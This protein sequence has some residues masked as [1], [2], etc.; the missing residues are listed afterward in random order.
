MRLHRAII[1][2]IFLSI[3]AGAVAQ[4]TEHPS[5]EISLLSE[6][7]QPADWDI[8]SL[9]R[10][11]SHGY[12]WHVNPRGLHAW[13]GRKLI[14]YSLAPDTD[15]L[16]LDRE[17][18][19][20][21]AIAPS[22][23]NRYWLHHQDPRT[24]LHTLYLW[25][26]DRRTIVSVITLEE[27]VH[28]LILSYDDATERSYLLRQSVARGEI[29]VLKL[30]SDL[31]ELYRISQSI[32]Q[33]LY[34]VK[35]L[36][37]T[38]WVLKGEYL[39][40]YDTAGHQIVNI[41]SGSYLK[42]E[43]TDAL[44]LRL[45]RTD[46]RASVTVDAS[47]GRLIPVDISTPV[48]SGTT[49]SSFSFDDEIWLNDFDERIWLYHPGTGLTEDYTQVMRLLKE[50][51]DIKQRTGDLQLV[52]SY[53]DGSYLLVYQGHLYRADP[54][55]A[56]IDKWRVPVSTVN[57]YPSIRQI[58]D[59]SA[60]NIYVSYY[61][62]VSVKRHDEDHF[63][64][65]DLNPRR[66]F[67]ESYS[68]VHTAT[69]LIWDG[70]RYR[71][72]DAQLSKLPGLAKKNT[73]VILPEQ[74][75]LWTYSRKAI[76]YKTIMPQLEDTVIRRDIFE[77]PVIGNALL[78]NANQE[79][80]AFI[81]A[82]DI[83]G[84]N[85]LR[86][87]GQIVKQLRGVKL[88]LSDD[89]S[90]VSSLYQ[91]DDRLYYGTRL[92]IG[93]LEA[94]SDQGKI[95]PE[96]TRL[97][98][99]QELHDAIYFIHPWKEAHLLLGTGSGLLLFDLRTSVIQRLPDSHPLGNIE[100][101]RNAH[102]LAS[103]GYTYVGSV[104]G[105]F[106]IDPGELPFTPQMRWSPDLSVYE[107][108]TYDRQTDAYRSVSSDLMSQDGPIR[109]RTTDELMTIRL[110]APSMRGD[111]WYAYSMEGGDGSWS[112]YDTRSDIELLSLPTGHFTVYLRAS[113]NPQ[114]LHYTEYQ[115][116]YFRPVIWYE[117][118][119]LRTLGALLL[120]GAVIAVVV[121]RFRAKVNKEKALNQWRI[122]VSSD[123]HDD[124]GSILSG[125]AMQSEIMSMSAK[126][127]D[128]KSLAEINEMS[129]DAMERMRDTVW[130]IDSRKDKYENLID[131][132]RAFAMKRLP[133]ERWHVD[134]HVVGIE[135]SEK[136]K[137][138]MRQQLYLIH[139]EAITN[140]QKH[141][142]GNQDQTSRSANY[143]MKSTMMALSIKRSV[144]M[145]WE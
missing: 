14:T 39:A 130:L 113:A 128:K 24:Y 45:T 1:V 62:D 28:S 18:Q 134:F 80:S 91:Y 66:S 6:A 43:N 81:L 138:V 103:D 87:D 55:T 145:V 33:T 72:S 89:D 116:E 97:I 59:D 60:G 61:T 3:S 95:L 44:T 79:Q 16:F 140:I 77:K 120:L 119:W 82:T 143:A 125:L 106:R 104:E 141:S 74:D 78:L 22:G 19:G 127:S 118:W 58:C 142:T 109:L 10:W 52:M 38:L 51:Y 13:D 56:S 76:L 63:S 101:N 98:D 137:P 136:I 123:L 40:A 108:K 121:A 32:D 48:L 7:S 126:D 90:Y 144:Q 21:L 50:R 111:V 46:N 132:M 133:E 57:P 83:R 11:D 71:H 112:R 49:Y 31:K 15:S 105:L 64:S 68:L 65:L 53:A 99:G 107:V 70:Y 25:D 26:S 92:G 84:I 117:N 9:P 135:G 100:Y 124:V 34:Q 96:F 115:L 47:S 37:D 85:W 110:S 122:K 69:H 102:F 88:G 12:M 41:K 67:V 5:Y 129:R 94:G 42:F 139:K 131:K 17:G 27:P 30:G 36:R 54:V 35:A 75:T 2:W 114:G 73:A 23:S 93:E 4:V 8:K 86:R 20:F 29:E